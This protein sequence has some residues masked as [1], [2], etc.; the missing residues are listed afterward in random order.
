[1]ALDLE[2]KHFYIKAEYVDDA[3]MVGTLVAVS[4]KG[5]ACTKLSILQ[6]RQHHP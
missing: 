4:V 1:M 3:P 6:P 5:A 2:Q